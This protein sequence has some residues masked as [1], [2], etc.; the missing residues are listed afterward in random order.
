[1]D[2][3]ADS[4]C[5]K[6]KLSEAD[7]TNAD[8]QCDVSSSRGESDEVENSES[9]ASINDIG[10]ASTASIQ[11]QLRQFD[12]LDEVQGDSG[13]ENGENGDNGKNFCIL[14]YLHICFYFSTIC[15]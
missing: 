2:S 1:M 11:D 3:T 4:T 13:S 9:A 7:D 5:R 8:E 6:R 15:Y 14:F 12:V 10:E